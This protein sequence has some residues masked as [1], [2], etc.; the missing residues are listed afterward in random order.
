MRPLL[1]SR[2]RRALPGGIYNIPWLSMT[3]VTLMVRFPI[4]IVA[5]GKPLTLRD[6]GQLLK[7]YDV[8]F[9]SKVK[10]FI[11]KQKYSDLFCNWKG[12]MIGRGEIWINTVGKSFRLRIVAINN[13]PPWSPEDN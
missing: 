7:Y 10:A 9:D 1:W 3:V 8:A 12:I 2:R 11:A 5:E 4:R 6:R 13:N